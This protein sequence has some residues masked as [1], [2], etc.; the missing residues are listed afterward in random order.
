ME[1]QDIIVL[2]EPFNALDFRTYGEIKDSIRMLKAEGKTI[3]LISHNYSDIDQLCDEVF[4]IED[5]TFVRV[6][7]DMA[8]HFREA[9]GEIRS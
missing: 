8:A 4:T 7:E 2:D 6:T 3:L 9:N 5:H 1:N